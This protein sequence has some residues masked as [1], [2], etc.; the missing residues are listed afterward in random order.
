M[1][2]EP[3][4]RAW[5]LP[6]REPVSAVTQR[7]E[8]PEPLAEHRI[9]AA[10]WLVDLATSFDPP[11][12]A[13]EVNGARLSEAQYV[14]RRLFCAG[15]PR[16]GVPGPNG[17]RE[18]LC[19]TYA[20]LSSFTGASRT[21]PQW[22][23]V[24]VDPALVAG[25]DVVALTLLPDASGR[26]EGMLE[27]G[28]SFSADVPRLVYGPLPRAFTPGRATSI[29]RWHVA[30]DWHLWGMSRWAHSTREATSTWRICGTPSLGF[31][32]WRRCWRG[33]TRAST[34]AS[35]SRSAMDGM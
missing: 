13:L 15:E 3:R 18:V 32:R 12:L 16:S 30:N 25:R 6:L 9:A 17:G 5:R 4:W 35:G 24:E 28:G 22:W 26:G 19:E 29:Y 23:A 7:L 31:V 1:A 8:L 20:T 10:R 34:F 14:W 2:S 11:P 33:A 21:S 27:L